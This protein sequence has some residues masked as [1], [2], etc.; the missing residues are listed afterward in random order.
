MMN[1]ENYTRYLN[2]DRNIACLNI[3]RILFVQ[4]VEVSK[5]QKNINQLFHLDWE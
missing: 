5:I 1:G 3:R 2:T 4:S